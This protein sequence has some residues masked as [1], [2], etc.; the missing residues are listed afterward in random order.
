MTVDNPI[1]RPTRCTWQYD[2]KEFPALR[3]WQCIHTTVLGSERCS[4]HPPVIPM[5][6]G[7]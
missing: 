6:D 4:L 1:I 7:G 5:G 3:G 2:A